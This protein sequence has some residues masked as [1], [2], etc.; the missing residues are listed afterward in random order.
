GVKAVNINEKTGLT[1]EP[2]NAE[3]LK[4]A[5][6]KLINDNEKYNLYAE[7]AFSHV[8]EKFSSKKTALQILKFYKEL[9]N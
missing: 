8:E 7:N 4:N 5:V 1:V 9:V 3:E 2:G 6:I